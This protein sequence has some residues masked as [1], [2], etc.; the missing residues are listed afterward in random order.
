MPS[1]QKDRILKVLEDRGDQGVLNIE[2]N[3]IA[4]RYG[5]RLYEL[6]QDGYRIRTK[7][8]R[9]GVWRFTLLPQD[10]ANPQSMQVAAQLDEP[11][12]MEFLETLR[13]S[14]C[15]GEIVVDG[16]CGGCREH[17]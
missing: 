15:C 7:H 17:V 12:Y 14:D 3:E 16:F 10:T 13:P 11:Q 2:L 5:G 8:V 6:R 4:F 1:T 9:K